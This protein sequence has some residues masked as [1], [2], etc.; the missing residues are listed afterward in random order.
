MSK[1]K[2]ALIGSTVNP[3]HIRNYY[4]LI[5]DYFDDILIIGTNE[6]DFCTSKALNFSLKNPIQV[7]RSI[8]ELREILEQFDPTFVHVHQAN[9]IGFITSLA[10]N[11]RYPQVLTT[12]GDDVL[13]NPY[14]SKLHKFITTTCLKH[15][16]KITA[17]AKSMAIS[18]ENFYKKI[19]VSILNFGIDFDTVLDVPKENIIYSNRLHNDLYNIDQIIDG[20]I[21]FLQENNDWK[22]IIAAV[23][24]NTEALKQLASS[25]SVANQIEFV[26]FLSSKDNI[27]N[28]LKS[29]IYVS[30]PNT[31]GTA[32]SLLESL[33]YGCIPVVSNIPS[34]NEWITDG[35]NGIINESKLTNSLKKAIKL[36]QNDVI[37][38]NKQI[39]AERATKDVNRKGFIQ[40]YEEILGK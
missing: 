6:V 19:P 16:D 2:L 14:R 13:T 7:Y 24:N 10:N 11:G 32:I 30:I 12:W 35:V 31:D 15:S 18:I 28:Y 23:G 21:P 20:C 9:S 25:S 4:N 17:D 27:A 22:L 37:K 8:K 5:K 39:I 38:I 29:K 1:K 26:G 40:I 34:N 36:N 3:V 33:A